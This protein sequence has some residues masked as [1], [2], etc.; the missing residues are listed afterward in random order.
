MGLLP[1]RMRGWAT[2]WPSGR[3]RGFQHG[4]N[5]TMP[6]NMSIPHFRPR[7]GGGMQGHYS[8]IHHLYTPPNRHV[9]ANA[10]FTHPILYGGPSQSSTRSASKSTTALSPGGSYTRTLC[11]QTLFWVFH[12]PSLNIEPT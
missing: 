1:S 10:Q 11:T 9:R 4:G 5:S 12:I 7:Y 6:S 3:Y 8:G 2:T